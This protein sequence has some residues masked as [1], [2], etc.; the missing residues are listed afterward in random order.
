MMIVAPAACAAPL[1]QTCEVDT[2]CGVDGVCRRC[3][4]CFIHYWPCCGSGVPNACARVS[5]R[6]RDSI[7][8]VRCKTPG[9][10]LEKRSCQVTSHA[11]AT[12]TTT[13]APDGDAAAG[14]SGRDPRSA[15]EARTALSQS[16]V[17]IAGR[18]AQLSGGTVFLRVTTLIPRKH[19]GTVQLKLNRL[20]RQLFRQAGGQLD[21]FVE[22]TVDDGVHSP[23]SVE[24]E[25]ALLRASI[26]ERP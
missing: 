17:Q 13:I 4:G 12:T 1:P 11:V 20:G 26:S 14:T 24:R 16:R 23:S 3:D 2:D 19:K 15:L 5:V 7:I 10:R 25:V 22:V 6:S 9:E 8:H 18:T 21:V